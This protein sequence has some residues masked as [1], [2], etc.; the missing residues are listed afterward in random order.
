MRS[1][2]GIDIAASPDL[3]FGIARDVTTW[4]TLLPHYARSR[5]IARHDDGSVTCL[6]VARRPLIPFLGLGLPVAWRSR[7]WS[8]SAEPGSTFD[9]WAG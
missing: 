8:N 4:E 2:I 6:F 9:T 3:V 5:P 7:A 1:T